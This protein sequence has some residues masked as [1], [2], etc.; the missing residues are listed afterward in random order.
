MKTFKNK[1]F[2]FTPNWSGFDIKYHIA[3]YF[4]R[5][6]MLQIYFIWGKLFL[7]LP[8][9]HYKLV[10]EDKTIQEKRKDKLNNLEGKIIKKKLVK[11]YYDNCCESP[12]YGIYYHMNQLG[13]CYGKKTKLYDMPWILDWVRTS[14]LR[15]DGTWEHE[16]VLP[17]LDN[18][19]KT[20]DFW[21]ESK[22]KGILFQE[23]HP[24]RYITKN[25][26]VQDVIA[27]IRVEE[28]EW[29][30]KWFKWFKWIR[31]IRRDIEIDFSSDIGEKKGSYKGGC[32][33]CSYEMLKKETPFE[34]LKRMERERIFK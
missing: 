34:T 22:W 8:W 20:K 17:T 7:Y 2:E 28:R 32:V 12:R 15:I 10:E 5:R 4:D 11:K 9:L 25:G 26:N 30:L 23:K 24:Y 16:G 19:K 31:K 13:I 18:I 6:P 33:G 1:Y 27:T 14:A 21:D 3:G 29:R